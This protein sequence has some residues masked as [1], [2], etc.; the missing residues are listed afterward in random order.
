MEN[1]V[2]IKAIENLTHNVKR[3]QF[4]KPANYT[5]IPGQATDVAI[6]KKGWEAEK[7]PFSFTSLATSPDLEFTIK[8]YR[9]HAGVTNELDSLVV[10]DELIIEDVWGAIA[11]HGPG[12]FIAGGAGITPFIAILRQLQK[13]QKLAGNKLFFSNKTEQDIILR[14]ELTAMLGANAIYTITGEPSNRYHHGHIDEPFL[15]TNVEDFKRHFYVC[16]PPPMV[17]GL[18]HILAR[19]G[20]SPEA[21]V[22]EK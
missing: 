6:N 20:A 5:F 17:E 22:F 11:Y 2:K 19:L 1:K 7:R 14:Q 18:Q 9:D 13:E 8:I 12:Y 16:G 3:F 4:E 10:G 21:V 15:K